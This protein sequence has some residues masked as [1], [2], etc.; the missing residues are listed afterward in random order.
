MFGERAARSRV[1][2]AMREAHVLVLTVVLLLVLGLIL[3][4]FWSYWVTL[5]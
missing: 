4:R 3:E 2:T 1:V 5:V